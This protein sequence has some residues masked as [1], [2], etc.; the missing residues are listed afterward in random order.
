MELEKIKE[1]DLLGKGVMGQ[2]E[3]P[4]ISAKEM[5]AAVEQIVR[6]VAIPKINEVIE[7]I[8]EKVATQKDLEK[9]LIDA[10]SV[11]SVFGRAGAVKAQ[12]GDY[13]PEMVGAAKEKHAFE[14]AKNGKD[15]ILPKDIGAAEVEHAHGNITA[16]GK[17][18][19]TNGMVL[20]TGLLGKIEA[21]SKQE[22]GFVLPPVK[23]EINGSFTAEDNTVYYGN[24]ISDFVFV[25]DAEKTAECRGIFTFG[26][27]GTID[28]RG[29]D[30]IEDPEE[31]K[32][33]E[34][35]SRWEFDLAEGCLIIRKRSE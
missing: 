6:E 18:G 26:T 16:E 19:D 15:P 32:N 31:I 22:I 11:S 25:C 14:H 9:L 12:K 8:I 21:K 5:Q 30:F 33:A 29:F 4:G 3:V 17:I 2:P 28:V 34:A 24:G 20:M 13:T 1:N 7:Y 10:G 27:P 23:K 35:G